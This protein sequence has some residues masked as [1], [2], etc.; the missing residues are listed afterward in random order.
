MSFRI[1]NANFGL[2]DDF[3]AQLL[4]QLAATFLIA[5]VPMSNIV[6]SN[7]NLQF[8]TTLL[9]QDKFYDKNI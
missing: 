7:K 1:W 3:K 8:H 2:L 5:P 6:I 4:F 9:I